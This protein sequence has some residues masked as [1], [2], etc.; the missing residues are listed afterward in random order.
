MIADADQEQ[1]I[2]FRIC[3]GCADLPIQAWMTAA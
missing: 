3:C 1:I 2:G